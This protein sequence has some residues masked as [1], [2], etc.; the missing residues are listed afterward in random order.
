MLTNTTTK[1]IYQG[2]G[3]TIVFAIPFDIVKDLTGDTEVEVILRDESDPLNPVETLQVI[4]TNY[5]LT[6]GSPVTDVTMVVAPPATSKLLVR[7]KFPLTQ[8]ADYITNGGF[9]AE[10]HELAL[11]RKVAMIQMLNEIFSRLSAFAPSSPTLNKT[12]PEPQ[13]GKLLGW[14]DTGLEWLLYAVS[15]LVDLDSGLSAITKYS[16]NDGAGP[17]NLS[18]QTVPGG[19]HTSA[20]YEYEIIRGITV[21]ASG[22][23]YLQYL[24]STWRLE[25]AGSFGDASGATFAVTQVGDLAQ[26]NVTFDVGAGNGTVKVY[27]K[28]FAV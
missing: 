6:G 17:V 11:D 4:T 26:L 25:D 23:F 15:D 3:A 21:F 16:I 18:G 5:T 24:N 9:P 20:V 12:M 2:N 10:T 19:T 8:I 14:N 28:L 22:K 13:A 27:R 1:Q 7:R